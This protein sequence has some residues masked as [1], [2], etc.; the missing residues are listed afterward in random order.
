MMNKNYIELF[1][2]RRWKDAF[3]AMPMNVPKIVEVKSLSD[4]PIIRVRASEFTKFNETKRVSVSLD[5][6]R[7]LAIVTVTKK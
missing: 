2:E 5:Y 1:A 4:L 6:D 3:D 7:K